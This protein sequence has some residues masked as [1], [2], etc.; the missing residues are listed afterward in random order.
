MVWVELLAVM[1]ERVRVVFAL[2]REIK[3]E[4]DKR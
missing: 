4:K 3:K 1:M 2:Y